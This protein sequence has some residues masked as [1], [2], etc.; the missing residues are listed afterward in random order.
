VLLACAIGV[1]AAVVLAGCGG[2]DL[3]S[4]AVAKIDGKE[5]TKS[6]VDSSTKLQLLAVSQNLTKNAVFKSATPK[7]VDLSA[8]YTECV[9][10]VK[11][12]IPKEQA[13]Q[14]PTSALTDYCKTL[15]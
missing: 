7:L 5:I 12:T 13:A 1:P 15:P 4:N 3:S 10:L 9:R 11:A 2:D 8:P 6:A 14:T